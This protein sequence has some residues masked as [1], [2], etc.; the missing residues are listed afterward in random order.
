MRAVFVD[1]RGR[2]TLDTHRARSLRIEGAPGD[3]LD[4]YERFT[5]I[6]VPGLHLTAPGPMGDLLRWVSFNTGV[7]IAIITG[8]GRDRRGFRARMAVSWGARQLLGSSFPAIG[9]RLG[10]R[11]HSTIMNAVDRANELIESDPAFR[12]LCA[13]MVAAQRGG[14]L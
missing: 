3:L 2:A 13:R 5:E 9:R 12:D 6:R 1:G 4:L 11:D 7:P 8:K 14:E 10:D